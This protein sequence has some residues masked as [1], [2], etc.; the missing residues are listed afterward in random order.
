MLYTCILGL[1]KQASLLFDQSCCPG[2]V[3]LSQKDLSI[4]LVPYSKGQGKVEQV[5][6]Q[7][8]RHVRVKRLS[9]HVQ[10]S[11]AAIHPWLPEF[12]A[13]IGFF[14]V[15]RAEWHRGEAFEKAGCRKEKLQTKPCKRKPKQTLAA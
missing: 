14:Q 13:Q 3:P 8:L 1:A 11:N 10:G 9:E 7:M 12:L 2:L 15:R 6:S 5:R 4:H